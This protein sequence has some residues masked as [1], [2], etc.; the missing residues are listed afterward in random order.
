MNSFNEV[1]HWILLAES[2]SLSTINDDPSHKRVIRLPVN[3]AIVEMNLFVDGRPQLTSYLRVRLRG[4]RALEAI[5]H[6]V[7]NPLSNEK[8]SLRLELMRVTADSLWTVATVINQPE[9]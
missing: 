8:R 1:Q 2:S 7:H 3:F 4:L 5:V 6:R 9:L